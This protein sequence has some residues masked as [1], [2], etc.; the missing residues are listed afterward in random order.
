MQVEG[1][2]LVCDK[3]T[4]PNII[5]QARAENIDHEIVRIKELDNPNVCYVES[6][7][8]LTRLRRDYPDAQIIADYTGGT[9][10][11]STGLVLAALDTGGVVLGVQVGL[12]TGLDKVVPGTQF[13][14]FTHH[15]MPLVNRQRMSVASFFQRFDYPAAMALLENILAIPDLPP[16]AEPLQ[17]SLILARGLNAWDRFD[18][19]AAWQLLNPFRA[20]YPP[21]IMFLEAVVWSRRNLD[22]RFNQVISGQMGD[23]PKGHGYELVQDLML[24]AERRATQ[25]R[26]DDAVARLYRALEMLAQAQLKLR[27]GL[28]TGNLDTDKLPQPSRDLYQRRATK[29]DGRIQIG[30]RDAYELLEGL[31]TAGQG[32]DPVNKIYS[33][34]K[35]RMRD[36]LGIRN[37]SLYAHGFSPIAKAEYQK[38]QDFATAFLNQAIAEVVKSDGRLK[39]YATPAQFPQSPLALAATG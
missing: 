28:D 35:D 7:S 27:Y 13:T 23:R 19:A 1:Q 15:H 37:S 18:H 31:P 38:A 20:Q 10:S 39:V 26:Y 4:K 16:V 30:L 24:N 32:P 34:Q 9:K 8:L 14:R 22:P 36:F 17:Q 25:G 12:R 2:G 5:T 21:L 6:L 3:D 11:M 29:P 33:A